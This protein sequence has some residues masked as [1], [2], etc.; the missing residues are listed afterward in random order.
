MPLI[1]NSTTEYL[2]EKKKILFTLSFSS[3]IFNT[4][5]TIFLF[6]FE[7]IAQK[8]D[9]TYMTTAICVSLTYP[10]TNIISFNV[11]HGNRDH[12]ISN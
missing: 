11:M 12:I 3:E 9:V 5:L 10:I 7:G 1:L 8:I 6:I 2:I 4:Q